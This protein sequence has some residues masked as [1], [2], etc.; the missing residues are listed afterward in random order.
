VGGMSECRRDSGVTL[1][2]GHVR[3]NQ[4]ASVSPGRAARV[5]VYVVLSLTV[6][7]LLGQVAVHLLPDFLLRD[8]L[9]AAFNV[10]GEGNVPALY[11]ALAILSC[12]YLLRVIGRVEREASG[13]FSRQWTLMSIIFFG[14]ACDEFLGFHEGL[15]D[16]ADLSSITLFSWVAFGMGFV[17]VFALIFFRTVVQL[18]SPTRRLFILAG[19]IYLSGAIGMETVA[20]HFVVPVWGDQGMRYVFCA[21]IEEFLEMMGIVVFIYALLTYLVQDGRELALALELHVHQDLGAKHLAA[22]GRG[23]KRGRYH[24]DPPQQLRARS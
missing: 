2:A 11:S 15:N 24:A 16:N 17:S 12:A 23:G 10:D 9:A 19:L 1:T 13:R 20:G 7:S 5:L 6:L 8:P 21:A 18:P 22:D 4:G 14:L 3:L